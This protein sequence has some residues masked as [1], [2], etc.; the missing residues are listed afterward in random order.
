MCKLCATKSAASAIAVAVVVLVLMLGLACA[1]AEAPQAEFKGDPRTGLVPLTVNFTDESTGKI[2][3]WKWNF[4]DGKTDTTR[5][6]SHTY[7]TAG[8]HNVSLVV[9]GPGGEDS[10]LKSYYVFVLKISEAA[11]A[12][13]NEAQ[14]AIKQCMDDAG[15]AALFASVTDWD[16]S[17]G[18]VTASGSGGTRDAASYLEGE[19]FKAEYDVD[20]GGTI[21]HGTDVSWGGI[22]WYGKNPVWWLDAST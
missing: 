13:V 17:A 22:K 2:T 21:F 12:E 8:Q 20:K 7:T 15:A 5:N 3:S 9:K 11:N 6:P 19:T 16:G 10:E 18:K 1:K 14:G 4:F